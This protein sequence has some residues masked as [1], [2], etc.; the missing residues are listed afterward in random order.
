M[1]T[2]SQCRFKSSSSL[3]ADVL[4]S[5]MSLQQQQQRGA[6]LT[7]AGCCRPRLDKLLHPPQRSTPP[8]VISTASAML[9]LA[10]YVVLSAWSTGSLWAGGVL[11]AGSCVEPV[12]LRPSLLDLWVKCF[13]CGNTPPLHNFIIDYFKTFL[14]G[15]LVF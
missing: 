15:V 5:P 10:Q 2:S 11:R 8:F 13:P 14:Y 12:T 1:A 6:A 3:Q 7:P 9:L 4:C